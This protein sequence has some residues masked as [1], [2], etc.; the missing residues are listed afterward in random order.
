[1]YPYKGVLDDLESAGLL[2]SEISTLL[3]GSAKTPAIRRKHGLDDRVMDVH[4]KRYRIILEE[5][6][7]DEIGPVWFIKHFKPY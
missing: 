2:V 5:G 6:D 1:L 7:M 3:E 4:G